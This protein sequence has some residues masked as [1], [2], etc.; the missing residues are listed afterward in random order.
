MPVAIASVGKIYIL[1][2]NQFAP[3]AGFSLLAVLNVWSVFFAPK[4]V[5]QFI[6]NADTFIEINM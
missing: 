1:L 5:S 6:L 3:K 2:T 4:I